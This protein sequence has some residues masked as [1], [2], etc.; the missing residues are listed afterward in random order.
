MEIQNF[1]YGHV[2]VFNYDSALVGMAVS[3]AWQATWW[4]WWCYVATTSK[5]NCFKGDRL[6]WI[7]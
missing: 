2:V 1:L 4:W 3:I 6:H 5:R 7:L